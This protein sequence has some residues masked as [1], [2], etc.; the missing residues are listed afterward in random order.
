[1]QKIGIDEV[2]FGQDGEGRGHLKQYE[3]SCAYSSLVAAVFLL[4][5][6]NFIPD[7]PEKTIRAIGCGLRSMAGKKERLVIPDLAEKIND[8]NGNVEAI[9][10]SIIEKFTK[11]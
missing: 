10:T 8:E 4:H 2:V 1:M 9:V 11:Y 5:G 3:N 7:L 6:F